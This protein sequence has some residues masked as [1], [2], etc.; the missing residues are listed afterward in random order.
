M[1]ADILQPYK[2]LVEFLGKALG[3]DYEVVLQDLTPGNKCIVA[4]ANGHI[5]G[6]QAGSPL[7]NA[8]LQMISSR[9][10]ESRDFLSNYKGIA[11]NGHVLRS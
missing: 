11:E 1:L 2:V 3:P 4:I 5:S 8:G 9:L 6:R 10:Y 7:T